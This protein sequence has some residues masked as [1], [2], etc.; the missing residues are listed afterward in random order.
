MGKAEGSAGRQEVVYPTSILV[1][2]ISLDEFVYGTCHPAPR[3]LKI[4]IEGGEVLALPGMHR[5]LGEAHPV[6]LLELHGPDA[7]QV[8]WDILVR[9]GYRICRMAPGFP[10]VPA[11]E[12]LDWKSYIVGLPL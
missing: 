7:A 8:A 12:T 9:T 2:G 6:V 10:G 3:L 4:D 1:T 5:V 11:V